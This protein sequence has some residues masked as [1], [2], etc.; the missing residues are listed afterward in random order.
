MSSHGPTHSLASIAPDLRAPALDEDK[1]A[2]IDEVVGMLTGNLEKIGEHGRRADGIV[3][4]MLEH[5]RGGTGERREVDLNGLVE[6]ALNLA[7]HALAPRTRISTSR[8]SAISTRRS[9]RSSWCRRM[10]RGCCSTSSATP[11]TPQPR[12]GPT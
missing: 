5:S 7:Y 4:S 6:E 8:S 12:A 1:R 3:K 11:S 9:P 10:S 2:D